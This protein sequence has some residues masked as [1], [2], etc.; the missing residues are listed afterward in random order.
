MKKVGIAPTVN[1][2]NTAPT[3][4]SGGVSALYKGLGVVAFG[5]LA[6]LV[7][8]K[9]ATPKPVQASSPSRDRHVENVLSYRN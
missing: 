2:S 6:Y 4:E 8:K 7:Y 3:E 1:P 9:L 5:V